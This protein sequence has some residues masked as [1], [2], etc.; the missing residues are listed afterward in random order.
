MQGE[1]GFSESLDCGGLD[2]LDVICGS[3]VAV[4]YDVP[5]WIFSTL[6]AEFAQEVSEWVNHLFHQHD[7]FGML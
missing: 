6:P 7:V 1:V 4:G 5:V 2:L 3:A